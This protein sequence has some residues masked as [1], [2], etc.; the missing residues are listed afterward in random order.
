MTTPEQSQPV[1]PPRTADDAAV[2]S[3]LRSQV[4]GLGV[5]L[6]VLS[7]CFTAVVAKQDRTLKAGLENRRQQIKQMQEIQMRWNPALEE[8]ARYSSG[9]PDLVALFARHGIQLGSTNTI[10]PA[11]AR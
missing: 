1:S 6:L 11:P 7:L 2:L 10:A 4:H 3:Q 5:G 8:L 9:K